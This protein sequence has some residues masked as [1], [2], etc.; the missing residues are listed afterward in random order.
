[1]PGVQSRR[2]IF[3]LN[4]YTEEEVAD[5]EREEEVFTYLLFGKEIVS[6]TGTPHLQGYFEFDPG[7]VSVEPEKVAFWRD[8]LLHTPSHPSSIGCSS[9]SSPFLRLDILI[10]LGSAVTDS[11][12]RGASV[13]NLPSGVH[14][15]SGLPICNH[16]YKFDP[17]GQI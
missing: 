6:S 15:C 8:N 13:C 11:A 16:L 14:S 3:T 12:P 1:M 7:K 17:C 10:T 9:S 2:W 5:L 4:N